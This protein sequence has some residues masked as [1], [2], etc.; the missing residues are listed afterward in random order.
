VLA[1]IITDG[2]TLDDL[3]ALRERTRATIDAG[4]RALQRELEAS[5]A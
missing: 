5:P 4:R 3:P 2:L 1:P